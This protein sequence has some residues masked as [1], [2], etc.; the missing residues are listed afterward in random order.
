MSEKPEKDL[1]SLRDR[2]E[3]SRKVDEASTF[4]TTH[5]ASAWESLYSKLKEQGFTEDQAFELLKVYICSSTSMKGVHLHF[6]D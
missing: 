1:D 3:R 4:V 5:L 2:I 6:N